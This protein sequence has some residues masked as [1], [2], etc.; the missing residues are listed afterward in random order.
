MEAVSEAPAGLTAEILEGD[1]VRHAFFTRAGGVSTGLYASLN[2]GLG[3][4]DE[5]AR[6]L[7]NRARAAGAF[8][9]PPDALVTAYQVH[10]REAVTVDA[11][12]QIQDRP[13]ADAL[14][15]RTPG[16]V[17]GVLAADCAPVLFADADAG[18]VGAAH[19]GWRGARA[20]VLEA[21][22]EAMAGLGA[23]AEHIAAAI[24]PTIA[25]ASYEVGPEFPALF[26]EESAENGRFF[27]ASKRTGHHLFDL[28]GYVR[29][30]LEALGLG[31]VADLG[32][33]T[34]A[35]DAHFFS[36]R[37]ATLRREGSF[38]TSLSTIVL[39]G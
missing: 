10:G 6:V 31:R 37:R 20:G 18:V 8:G 12:W 1:S 3:S 14:T 30:K 9:C 19:A 22:V 33:D 34:C 13:R 7:E 26:L 2:C 16:I 23:R 29:G 27:Y 24:G 4:D 39:T 25:R 35:E 5:R 28:P 15:T 11:P 38:G 36:Y 21:A 32:R 17:L